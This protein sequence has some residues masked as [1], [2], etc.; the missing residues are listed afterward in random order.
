MQFDSPLPV[1]QNASF[2]YVGPSS[3]RAMTGNELARLRIDAATALQAA[4]LM[5]AAW[6]LQD[7]NEEMVRRE[8]ATK[9]AAR[10]AA[11]A[12]VA[13]REAA[14]DGRPRSARGG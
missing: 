11:R 12:E 5:D 7:T 6:M 2:R 9:A 10:G 13:A 8:E 4:G 1:P 14:D 3:M